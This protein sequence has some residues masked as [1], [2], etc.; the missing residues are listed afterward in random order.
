[1]KRAEESKER[2]INHISPWKKIRSMKEFSVLVI[3]LVL[4]VFISIVSPAFLTVT[5]LRTTA[6]G[7]SCNAIIAIAMTLA[8]VSGGFALSVGSVL[9]L[10]AVSVVVLGNA[11]WN[12]WLA[13]IVGILAGIFCGAINGMLIGYLNLN[14]FITTLGM[15]QMARGL[16]YVLTNGG[17]I[18]LK[19]G[20]GVE[21]F[22]FIGS[23]SV[24]SVPMLVLVCLILV[25]AG[26]IL[27]RRSG[28]A[29][30]VFFV[31]SNEKT[32]MLSGI[33][34]RLVKTMVYVLTG[35]LSGLAG[36]LTASR[37]GTAT[38]STGDGVEMTVISAAVIGGVSLSGGKGTVAGAVLGVVMMSVISN[39]LVILNVSVHWQ[40]FI[41]GAILIAAIIF[42]VLSNRRKN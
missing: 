11:G 5:N 30:N 36:V 39:I 12:I 21:A 31:G 37:F 13:A 9:G 8:L 35:G 22:R 42:D 41:T 26:D 1:M 32:S 16:V 20:A 18:G 19:D 10:S 33:N 3:L 27:V 28:A 29:R 24:G 14:A 4:V 34:T 7:F 40:N 25:V 6:I 38:S 23:G 15:Q 2:E 17:S